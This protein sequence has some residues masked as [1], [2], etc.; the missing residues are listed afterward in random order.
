[1]QKWIELALR[2]LCSQVPSLGIVFEGSV[3]G[4]SYPRFRRLSWRV[5]GMCGSW[6]GGRSRVQFFQVSSCPRPDISVRRFWSLTSVALVDHQFK[7]IF[8]NSTK[9]AEL[10]WIIWMFVNCFKNTNLDDS[11]TVWSVPR[12]DCCPSLKGLFNP[13]EEESAVDTGGRTSS[14]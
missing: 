3:V 4:G 12:S 11:S 14:L 8:G 10:E 6:W 1:M 13:F 2:A 9:V 7:T 5:A